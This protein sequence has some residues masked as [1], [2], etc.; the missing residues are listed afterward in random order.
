MKRAQLHVCAVFCVLYL[1]VSNDLTFLP[2]P[3]YLSDGDCL[4][5]KTEDQQN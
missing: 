5:D 2:F 4:E 3:L 1:L